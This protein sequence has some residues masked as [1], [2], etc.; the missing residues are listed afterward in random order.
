MAIEKKT[1]RK[2]T[3]KKTK[4]EPVSIT[5]DIDYDKL[6]EAIVKAEIKAKKEIEE[7]EIQKQKQEEINLLKKYGYKENKKYSKIIAKLKMLFFRKQKDIQGDNV[8]INFLKVSVESLLV[9]GEYSLYILSSI[10]IY[11]FFK[12]EKNGTIQ[13]IIALFICLFFLVFKKEVK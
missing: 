12:V 1:N 2:E 11:A 4:E 13:F 6:A 3:K 8:T 9:F 5:F 10:L 7:N